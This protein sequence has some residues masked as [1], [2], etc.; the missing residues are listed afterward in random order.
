MISDVAVTRAISQR[1]FEKFSESLELDVAIVGAGPAGLVAGR[2]LAEAGKNVAL[3]ES[4][5]STGGG[6]WG[7]GMLFNEIV[8][9]KDA[10]PIM[11]DF[12]IDY[13]LHDAGC[14]TA[15]AVQT[16][17]ALTYGASKAGL[18][19]FNTC[20]VEDVLFSRDRVSGVVILW[21]PVTAAG[22]HVDP[23]SISAHVVLDA[24][25]HDSD[26]VHVAVRK[27]GVKLATETG[28][29]LGEKSMWAESGEKTV[30]EKTGEVFPGL[31]VAGMA[32]AAVH[33]GYRMGPIFGGMLLSGRK[34]A[35]QILAELG[36]ANS[37]GA[38]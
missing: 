20:K 32:A 9:R 25:G 12:G 23:L 15:D 33:G 29:I 34:A 26:I 22:L 30:V 28:G 7:G 8:V 21:S 24:T 14:Y 1:F 6:I 10:L 5:L 36:D 31:Y 35:K 18:K 13:R 27:M 2:Y 17:A 4:K 38:L 16:A 11:D 37:G 19:V 3:F